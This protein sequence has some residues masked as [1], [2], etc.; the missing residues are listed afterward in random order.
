MQ[1]FFFSVLKIWFIT[2][3]SSHLTMAACSKCVIFINFEGIDR[4]VLVFQGCES[5]D[6]NLTF[7]CSSQIPI[8]RLL[9]HWKAHHF[10]HFRLFQ[11]F[12]HRW[13][14]TPGLLFKVATCCAHTTWGEAPQIVTA[15]PPP[16]ISFFRPGIVKTSPLKKKKSCVRH[17]V[18]LIYQLKMFEKKYF[19]NFFFFEVFCNKTRKWII[20]VR[21]EHFL[22]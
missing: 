18:R 13:S 8:V 15:P 3:V 9:M 11:T 16:P 1:C 7:F 22:F 6:L 21:K 5:S 10:W 12:S 2:F 4:F 14:R 17:W 20:Q 19:H